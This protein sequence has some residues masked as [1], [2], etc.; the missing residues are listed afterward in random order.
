[1]AKFNYRMQNILN[2]KYMQE[3]QQKAAFSM[4]SNKVNEEQ[5][6]LTELF[7]RRAHYQEMLR[8]AQSGDLDLKEIM[9]LKN[10][11]ETMKMMIRDQMIA[12]KKAQDNLEKERRRLDAVMKDRKTHEKL[13]EKAFDQFKKDLIHDESKQT[14]ELTSY[15]YNNNS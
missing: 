11:I 15:R 2:L 6:K 14:D 12:V 4:A 3:D 10:A 5:Q 9:H 8:E 13:K 7:A 1:M